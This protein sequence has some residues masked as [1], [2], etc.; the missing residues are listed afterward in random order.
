MLAA[1]EVGRD[2]A[3]LT[4]SAPDDPN[5]AITRYEVRIGSGAWESTGSVGTYPHADR[6]RHRYRVFGVTVRAV[7]AEGE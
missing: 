5:P 3:T 1:S 7:N 6:T 2:S 4:W